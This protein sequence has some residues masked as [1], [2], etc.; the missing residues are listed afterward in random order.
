MFPRHQ[1]GYHILTK[2]LTLVALFCDRLISCFNNPCWNNDGDHEPGSDVRWYRG[3]FWWL[4]NTWP[5]FGSEHVHCLRD[6][7]T[8]PS[9]VFYVRSQ[10]RSLCKD[11]PTG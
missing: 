1:N 5:P 9:D 10:A 8:H 2:T 3:Y 7:D 6:Y 11:S 4:C